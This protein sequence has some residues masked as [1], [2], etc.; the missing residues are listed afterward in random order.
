ME[1]KET[2]IEGLLEIIPSVYAD[3]RGWFFEFFNKDTFKKHNINYNFVQENHS[4]SVKGVVRGLHFQLPPFEQAKLVTVV[5]GKVLDVVVDIRQGSRTFGRVFYCLLDSEKKN[6]LMVPEGFAHG[7]AA[8]EDTIFAYKC[9]NTYHREL[10]QGIIWN[11]PDLQ[12]DWQVEKPIISA[13][14]ASLPTLAELLRKSV[15]LR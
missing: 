4:H 11:D 10:E 7:F 5:K 12:I 1:V 14:D 3:E 15:I 9:S 13:K 6:M 2:G 8:V